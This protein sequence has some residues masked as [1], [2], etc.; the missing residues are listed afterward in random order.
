MEH[1]LRCPSVCGVL[2]T[3]PGIEPMSLVLQG[4]FLT[5]EPPAHGVFFLFQWK[6]LRTKC[7]TVVNMAGKIMVVI[8]TQREFLLKR[9][10]PRGRKGKVMCLVPFPRSWT[11]ERDCSTSDLLREHCSGKIVRE[12]EKERWR[13]RHVGATEVYTDPM[14]SARVGMSSLT[15]VTLRQ[16]D[17]PLI[18]SP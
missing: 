3:P 5:T 4:G 18:P 10:L 11:W 6:C 14:G 9:K 15:C 12:A 7:L 17:W 16:E 1:G 2:V 8:S 13:S